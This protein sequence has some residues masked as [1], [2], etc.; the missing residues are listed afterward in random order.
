MIMSHEA[1]QRSKKFADICEHIKTNIVLT[2][3]HHVLRW[4][5]PWPKFVMVVPF[6]S[7]PRIPPLPAVLTN[8]VACSLGTFQVKCIPTFVQTFY[9]DEREQ[10]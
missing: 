2:I 8:A 7:Y 4:A 9:L 5:I 3:E 10:R 1:I 6:P